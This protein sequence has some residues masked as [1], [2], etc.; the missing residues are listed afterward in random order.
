MTAD[1][2]ESVDPRH[3]AARRMMQQAREELKEKKRTRKRDRASSG[4]VLSAQWLQTNAFH[5]V[6]LA[7]ALTLAVGAFCGCLY[8][9]STVFVA[10]RVVAVPTGILCAVVASYV[11]HYFLTTI[12]A[13]YYET[14]SVDESSIA[15][16]R[17]WFWT[18]PSTLGM[19]I[20][21]LLLG[22]LIS[23]PL[24]VYRMPIMIG[25]IFFAYP[26][27]QLSTL[28]T[29]SPLIPVSGQL[30]AT[31][32][33][34]PVAWLLFYVVWALVFGLIAF[35]EISLAR[36]WPIAAVVLAGP[37]MAAVV[38][39]CSLTLGHLAKTFKLQRK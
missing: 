11:S 4:N 34:H 5:I 37:I 24:P 35:I 9:L 20:W 32:V 39:G 21:A 2:E 17:E 7:V 16:W 3:A 23:V 12:S 14:V 38:V 36:R 8:L 30:A 33:S 6:M 15:D 22:Y 10:G 1:N 28:E 13:T 25:V 29:E 19:L 18:L 31:F 26:Y 27:F